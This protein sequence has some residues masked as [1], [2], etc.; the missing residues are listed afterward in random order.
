MNI[1]IVVGRSRC[2][3]NFYETLIT[4]IKGLLNDINISYRTIEFADQ[5]KYDDD[6][7]NIYIG[8][9]HHTDLSN[10]PK[11]YI[12]LV[13][14]P[15]INC[16]DDMIIKIK[17]SNYILVYT[18]IEYFKNI[19][20]NIIYYPF[21]YHQS[22]ENMYNIDKSILKNRFDL[23]FICC[24]NNKRRNI[25]NLLKS[26]NYNIYCPNIKTNPRGIYEKEQDIL[27]HSSKIVLLNN[28]YQN[29]IDKPRMIYNASNK[30]FFIY[31]LNK[32]DDENLLDGVYNNI[33]VKC[34][35]NNMFETI[36]YYLKN[37]E[38]RIE[39]VNE[40]YNYVTNNCHIEKY[41]TIQEKMVNQD[42]RKST[43]IKVLKKELVLDRVKSPR[44]NPVML[45]SK[46]EILSRK[47]EKII[48]E[49]SN[50]KEMKK[51]KGKEERNRKE[52]GEKNRKKKRKRQERTK[53]KRQEKRKRHERSKE[54]SKEK[55]K[56]QER[57]KERSK[58]KRMEK[59][60]RQERKK[61]KRRNKKGL[62]G[63]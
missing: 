62:T 45:S 14:D 22:I 55:R 49:L 61:E 11:N 6:I 28:Y 33:I 2:M 48:K 30:I 38:K 19:N 4:P 46:V 56:R 13:M 51:K 50:R 16:N 47:V 15:A 23:L 54:R 24:L 8:I 21:P 42:P 3:G 17:N 25:Y 37:E 31:I 40:L 63:I 57:S 1:T 52:I 20:N 34:N 36:N 9:F 59:R 44:F 12:M 32:D 5:V 41:L 26:N 43:I 58:E 10:M 39:K 29:D 35:L 18:D 53:E 60:K 27:L 7:N